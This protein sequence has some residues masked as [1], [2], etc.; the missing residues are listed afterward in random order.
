MVE[1]LTCSTVVREK[2]VLVSIRILKSKDKQLVSSVVACINE[3]LGAGHSTKKEIK[4]IVR[5]DT[6]TVLFGAFHGRTLVGVAA[7]HPLD[8]DTRRDLRWEAK[9]LNKK[10]GWGKRKDVALLQFSV[11]SPKWR[12]KGVGKKLLKARMKYLKRKGFGV[13]VTLSWVSDNKHNS[14]RLFDA[15]GFKEHFT[16]PAYWREDTMGGDYVCPKCRGACSCDAIVYS[17]S[18]K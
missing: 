12:G 11:V 4:K 18:L 2:F 7:C 10:L 14:G 17:N 13:A 15:A 16:I 3:G 1:S 6:S 8:G 9:K 5:G